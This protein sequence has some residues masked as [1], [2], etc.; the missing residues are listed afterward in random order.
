MWS[1]GSTSDVLAAAPVNPA[2]PGTGVNPSLLPV[3]NSPGPAGLGRRMS[4]PT[5]DQ[6]TPACS[7]GTPN[8]HPAG[9]SRVGTA[10][11]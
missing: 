8:I 3:C 11:S 1:P 9:Q 10:D 6:Y 4:E 2:E 5:P 7:S